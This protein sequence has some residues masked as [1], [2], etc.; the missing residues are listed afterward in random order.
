MIL[1][2]VQF[3]LLNFIIVGFDLFDYIFDVHDVFGIKLS[4]DFHSGRGHGQ[5]VFSCQV[6]FVQ[7]EILNDGLSLLLSQF[8][9]NR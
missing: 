2:K 8:F 6:L 3:Y 4:D 9:K 7:F 5:I 1:K